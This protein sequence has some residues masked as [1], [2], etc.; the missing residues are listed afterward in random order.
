MI[1]KIWWATDP[2]RWTLG[3][4]VS[5]RDGHWLSYKLS[6]VLR[7]YVWPNYNEKTDFHVQLLTGLI[8]S[9]KESPNFWHVI[10]QFRITLYWNHIVPDRQGSG[11]TKYQI[12]ESPLAKADYGCL[13]WEI[14]V[15]RL[16]TSISNP[17]QK[18]VLSPVFCRK[19]KNGSKI[20]IE[21]PVLKK[22]VCVTQIV[23]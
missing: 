10:S 7:V 23:K 8:S 5:I 4:V 16:V 12:I 1:F 11:P 13:V 3:R 9:H 21:F 2:S 14:K 22:P 6:K 17:V 19:S 15:H 18:L 20:L